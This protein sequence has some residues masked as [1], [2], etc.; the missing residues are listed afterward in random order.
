MSWIVLSDLPPPAAT[1]SLLAGG[2]ELL[3]GDI[4]IVLIRGA[5]VQTAGC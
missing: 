3:E 1:L 5:I 2:D 4:N